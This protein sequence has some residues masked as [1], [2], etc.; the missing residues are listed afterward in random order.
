MAAVHQEILLS[1][2]SNK[3]YILRSHLTLEMVKMQK[4]SL[5]QSVLE[6]YL[7]YSVCLGEISF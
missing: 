6:K 7:S 5:T 1:H 4:E 2:S 3:A